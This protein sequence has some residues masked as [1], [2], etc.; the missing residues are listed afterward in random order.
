MSSGN[1][2]TNFVLSRVEDSEGLG[3]CARGLISLE[4]RGKWDNETVIKVM[5]ACVWLYTL[6]TGWC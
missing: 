6:S 1:L 5:E 2:L 3:A 4:E